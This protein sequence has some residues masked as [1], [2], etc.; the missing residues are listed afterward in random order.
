MTLCVLTAFAS[1]A[2][3][4]YTES[5]MRSLI[6][7][8]AS[9][10][11]NLINI[12]GSLYRQ[13]PG[14]KREEIVILPVNQREIQDVQDRA[15]SRVSRGKSVHVRTLIGRLEKTEPQRGLRG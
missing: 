5:A 12:P 11:G 7:S 13:D 10:P 1:I 2:I 6:L 15:R 8:S 3:S 14:Y 9:D 4:V